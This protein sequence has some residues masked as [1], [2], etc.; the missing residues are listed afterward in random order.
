MTPPKELK[1]IEQIK[2]MKVNYAE[3]ADK[4]QAI[5]PVLKEWVGY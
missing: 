1:P 2:T 5:Q 3:L 4:L